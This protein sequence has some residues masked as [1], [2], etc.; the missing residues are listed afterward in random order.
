MPYW[1]R[2]SVIVNLDLD[3]HVV[4]RRLLRTMSMPATDACEGAKLVQYLHD[5]IEIGWL[6]SRPDPDFYRNASYCLCVKC[7][8]LTLF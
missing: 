6:G 2:W 4:L 7:C 3:T 5:I 1:K 8:V